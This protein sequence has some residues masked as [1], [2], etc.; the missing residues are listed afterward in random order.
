ME[1]IL[2]DWKKLSLTSAEGAKI[3]LSKSKNLTSKE[4]VLA[5]KF[6]TKRALNVEAIRQTFKSLWRSRKEFKIREA[7]DHVLLFVF[8]LESDAKRVLAIE[9]WS[10]DKHIVL[11]QHYDASAPA[12]TLRFT[13][14]KFWVQIHGLPMRMLDPET[15]I[16]LG[17]TIRQVSPSVNSKEMIG[18]DFLWI[19]VEVDVSKPLCR[20][21]IVVLENDREIWVSFK[22]EKLS[23]FCYWCGMVSHDEK[24]CEVWLS[25]KGTISM[26]NREY[27]AWLRALSYNTGK[28]HFT[29][30]S[31]MGDGL[32]RTES[33][34]QTFVST[35]SLA[36]TA[37]PVVDSDRHTVPGGGD[38]VN[39][40]H[41]SYM[42]VTDSA[43]DNSLPIITNNGSNPE[44]I[45]SAPI[46]SSFL[47]NPQDFDLQI[48]EIDTALM[49]F[50]HQT[51]D[52]LCETAG[53]PHI[54]ESHEYDPDLVK[55]TQVTEAQNHCS[56]VAIP[57]QESTSETNSLRKWKKMARD[58]H[59]MTDQTS[60][61]TAT[62][63][64][65]ET[66]EDI[67]PELPTKKLQ[68]SREDVQEMPMVEAAQ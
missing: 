7:G 20:G 28:T 53:S 68:V 66:E 38:T 27:G 32:G 30:V 56:H 35:P 58:T 12:R 39:A 18:G 36:K 26:T 34:G 51:S 40:P 65:R 4:Y 15:A 43:E 47:T 14:V 33:V 19:R 13:K 31:G 10:F 54:L 9:P 6:L 60:F 29:T 64:G 61:S 57:N 59:M 11:F 5:V 16:E 37:T 49:K 67:Q 3:S 48:Q 41:M 1:E 45:N 22:Y 63:R 50:D 55:E 24:E 8:E 23:N 25:S 46:S 2:N 44:V 52:P 62:K 17:E 42:E 21:R